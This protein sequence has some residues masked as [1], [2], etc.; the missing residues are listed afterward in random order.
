MSGPIIPEGLKELR[1][2]SAKVLYREGEVFY[3]PIQE[4]N[5]DLSV[6]FLQ[7]FVDKLALEGPH[8]GPWRSDNFLSSLH[9]P[10]LKISSLIS[11]I[12]SEG[13]LSSKKT[14]KIS[15]GIDVLEGKSPPPWLLPTASLVAVV[16]DN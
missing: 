4:F 10:A 11:F 16:D 9:A 1:E 13:T 8:R 12:E 15:D 7:L 5:R 3:N 2:G 14:R 6:L